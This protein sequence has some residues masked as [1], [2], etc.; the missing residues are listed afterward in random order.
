MFSKYDEIRARRARGDKGFTLIELLVVV[1]IIGILIAIAIPLYLNYQKSSHDKAAA[2]DARNAV[3]AAENCFT[4]KNKYPA[5]VADKTD[6]YD[7]SAVCGTDTI[8]NL[9][10]G[11]ELTMTNTNDTSFTVCTTNS[12]GAGSV[13]KFDS[14]AGGKVTEDTTAGASC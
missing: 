5:A 8:I 4:T 11:T 13:Y 3:V 6:S 12:K 1:V 2:S 7:I 9:S 14:T 10:D